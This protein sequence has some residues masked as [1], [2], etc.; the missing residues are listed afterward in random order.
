MKVAKLFLMIVLSFSTAAFAGPKDLKIFKT[1]EKVG[2]EG[3]SSMAHFYLEVAQVEC[4]Y[5][6]LSRNYDCAMKDVSVD[7]DLNLSGRKAAAIFRL[8]VAVG[9]PSDN[10]TGKI[11]LSAKAIRCGQAEAGVADGS[12][13]DRTT[14]EFEF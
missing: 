1:L 4:A 11:M 8:L 9:A 14:C 3:R 2:V 13:A 10:G 12:E 7:R 5:S 6:E